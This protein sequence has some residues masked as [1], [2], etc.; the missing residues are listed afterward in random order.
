MALQMYVLADEYPIY[1]VTL[2]LDHFKIALNYGVVH[3]EFVTGEYTYSIRG[4]Y[5]WAS[6]PVPCVAW[7]ICGP[8]IPWVPYALLNMPCNGAKATE[9]IGD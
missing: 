7:G 9:A 2:D 3:N 1:P 5:I 4:E 8:W 6:G